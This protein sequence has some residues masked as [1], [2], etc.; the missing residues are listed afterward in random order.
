MPEPIEDRLSRL[1]PAAGGLDRDALLFAAGR[2]SAPPARRWQALSAVLAAAQV[3][4]LLLLWPRPAPPVAPAPKPPAVAPED[5]APPGSGPE[6]SEMWLLRRQILRDP[7][8]RLARSDPLE[9]A[10]DRPPLRAFGGPTR[11]LP[12]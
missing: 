12:D 11:A 2:R 4:T 3:V 9:V 7:D 1:T 10:P 8:G 5:V 6:G